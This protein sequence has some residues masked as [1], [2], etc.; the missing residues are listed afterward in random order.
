MATQTI[1]QILEVG[2]EYQFRSAFKEKLD[3]AKYLGKA[4]LNGKPNHV[5][6]TS[7]LEYHIGEEES[8]SE[9]EGVIEMGLNDTDC[10][11]T[12]LDEVRNHYEPEE[13]FRM[14]KM[15]REVGENI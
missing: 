1:P 7:L 11:V 3:V 13:R 5:F 15:L 4:D 9:S 8:L 14:L 2:K 12:T 10:F 6:K